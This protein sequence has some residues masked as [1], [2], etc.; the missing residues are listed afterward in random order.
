MTPTNV[1]FMVAIP[2]GLLGVIG[3]VL[4]SGR[5]AP[6][7]R[8]RLELFLMLAFYP[9]MVAVLGWQA[10]RLT[11]EGD[12]TGGALNGLIAATLAV[13]GVVMLRLRVRPDGTRT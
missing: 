5:L 1:F 3:L 10:V 6:A 8:R 4:I 12:W 2:L 9:G 13:Q 11:A 7:T